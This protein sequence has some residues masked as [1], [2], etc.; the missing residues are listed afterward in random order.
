M[1]EFHLHFIPSILL[2]KP[3]VPLPAGT[4]IGL[5]VEITLQ[6]GG[7]KG[8]PFLNAVSYAAPVVVSLRGCSS[9]V[10][11][12]KLKLCNRF[13][14]DIVSLFGTNFG[15]FDR[16]SVTVLINSAK[17]RVLFANDTQVDCVMPPGR[18]PNNQVVL[19]QASGQLFLSDSSALSISYRQCALGQ[20]VLCDYVHM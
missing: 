9:A 3:Q 16:A 17:C 13:G 4:G 5:S 7:I 14:G 6:P 19:V 18:T 1:C 12:N 2:E 20:Q 10:S 11:T 8:K 15:A